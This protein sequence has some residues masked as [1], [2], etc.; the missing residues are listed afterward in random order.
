MTS[1]A[2]STGV[3]LM[4]SLSSQGVTAIQMM[5]GDGERMDEWATLQTT[6]IGGELKGS[7]PLESQAL[8]SHSAVMVSDLLS[9]CG[10]V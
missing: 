3:A 9:F 10:A 6:C 4:P 8:A 2:S 1:Q 5:S 7:M